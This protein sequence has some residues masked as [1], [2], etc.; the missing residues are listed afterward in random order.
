MEEPAICADCGTE[1]DRRQYANAEGRCEPCYEDWEVDNGLVWQCPACGTEFE[2]AM[3]LRSHCAGKMA[4]D[5]DHEWSNLPI[6][7]H[8]LSDASV[9][10][11]LRS[12][13]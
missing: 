7:H 9:P 4:N 13:M 3:G 12:F 10:T 5:P 11:D 1:Y 8:D 6:G 2:T